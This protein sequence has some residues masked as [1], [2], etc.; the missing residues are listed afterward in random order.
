[1][2]GGGSGAAPAA[3]SG[4]AGDSIRRLHD[5]LESMLPRVEALAADR[6]RVEETNRAQHELLGALYAHLLQAEASRDRWKAAY[7]ELHPGT[8]PK[9]AELQERDVVDSQ[10]CETLPDSNNSQLQE[11]SEDTSEMELEQNTMQIFVKINFSYFRKKRKI[12]CLKTVSLELTGSHTI[13]DVKDK[14]QD[15]EGI[16]ARKQRLIFGSKLLVGSCTLKD[17]NIVEESTLILETLVNTIMKFEVCREDSIYNVKAKI[18]DETC[19]SP[20]RQCLIFAGKALEDGCTLADYNMYNGSILYLVVRFPKCQGGRMHVMVRTLT[21]KIMATEVEGEDS[22]YSVKVKVF[23]ETGVPPGRQHLIFAGNVMEDSRTLAD[24]NVHNEATI[25]LVFRL[26]RIFV[27]T[28]TGKKIF[29][30]AFM[31]SQTID[32]IKAW[33]YYQVGILPEQQQL[34]DQGGAPWARRSVIRAPLFCGSVHLV[35]SEMQR[36]CY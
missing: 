15:K 27:R 31:Q 26:I 10:A 35:I 16:P 29:E 17:Y 12:H 9:L 18:F 23:N 2:S 4:G 3:E 14:I 19:I 24:Y 28:V 8:N 32:D 7:T 20:G 1:M 13:F 36:S 30:H 6:A 11:T 22:I 21:D 5:R 33:I 34:S 25:Y